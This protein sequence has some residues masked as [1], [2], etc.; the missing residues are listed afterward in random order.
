MFTDFKALAAAVSRGE[1]PDPSKHFHLVI[2]EIASLGAQ[3]TKIALAH[4]ASITKLRERLDALQKRQPDEVSDGA[5][6]T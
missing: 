1:H 2:Q 5:Q 6:E 4:E 3:I